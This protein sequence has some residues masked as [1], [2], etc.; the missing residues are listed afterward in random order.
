MDTSVRQPDSA[1]SML[2]LDLTS[3]HSLQ[4]VE[5]MTSVVKDLNEARSKAAVRP[6]L[7]PALS[8]AMLRLGS[9]SRSV[10]LADALKVISAQITEEDEPLE[11]VSGRAF[12]KEYIQRRGLERMSERITEGSK[13]FLEG[14]A[15]GVVISEISQHPQVRLCQ[16]LLF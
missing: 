1:E 12:K 7:I 5:A 13:R 11:A 6:N 8:E 10:Q 9:D 4:R 2:T 16:N 15:W 14:L 3:V